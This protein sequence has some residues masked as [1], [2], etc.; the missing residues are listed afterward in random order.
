METPETPDVVH[1]TVDGVGVEVPDDGGTLLDVLRD[2]IGIRS[3]KDGCSPQ[4]QCGC[5]T[6]LV[7]GQARV[8]CVTPARRANGRTVTTLD[9]LDPEVRTAWAEAF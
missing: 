9:G 5:C 6:V 1:F 2:R 4:G 3:V 8:S 7:D